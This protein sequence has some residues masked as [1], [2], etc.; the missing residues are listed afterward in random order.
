MIV[1]SG[2]WY[3]SFSISLRSIVLLL[4]LLYGYYT[5]DANYIKVNYGT[6]KW[7]L[8]CEG[9]FDM[10][11]L[12]DRIKEAGKKKG[13][14]TDAEIERVCGIPRTLSNIKAYG[15]TPQ[16]ATIYKICAGLDITEEALLDGIERKKSPGRPSL[17]SKQQRLFEVAPKNDRLREFV[18]LLASLDEKDF[19]TMIDYAYYLK[20][21]KDRS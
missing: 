16:E 10:S 17:A 8:F 4:K 5:A 7:C 9:W 21:R 19:D 1:S 14:Y 2:S 3:N 6:I 18:N 15:V 12:Y 13:L 11:V 20:S